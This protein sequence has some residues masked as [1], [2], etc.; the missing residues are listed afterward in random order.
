MKNF[1]AACVLS[2]L[3]V[4]SAFAGGVDLTVNACPGNPGSTTDAGTL[5]CAGGQQLT[6]LVTFVPPASMASLT[7]FHYDLWAIV[8][9]DLS[10]DATFWDFDDFN[11]VL[12]GWTPS[13]DRP[14]SG[15]DDYLAGFSGPGGSSFSGGTSHAGSLLKLELTEFR[16]PGIAI[17][18]GQP[19]F[20]E[21]I[22]IDA[23][24]SIDAGGGGSGCSRSVCFM[25]PNASLQGG[26]GAVGIEQSVSLLASRVL[27]IN[28]SDGANCFEVP[29]K[30]H[31][32]G[33]LKSLYR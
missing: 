4:A 17:A 18:A 20:A 10:T 24:T 6:L 31:T 29:V 1:L 15:C 26:A 9:G 11:H 5:D 16:S 33:Q 22:R 21:Q 12:L 3:L 25:I 23:S 7:G 8:D 28:G 30:R 32:W 13:R 2:S 19:V 27:T 14:A